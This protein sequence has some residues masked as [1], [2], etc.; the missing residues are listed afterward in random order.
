MNQKKAKSIANGVMLNAYPDSIGH[1]LSDTIQMLQKPEFKDVFA[2]F[3]V[4]PTFFNSDLD[5]GFS[6]LDYNLNKDLV[7]KED[8]IALEQLNIQLKFDIVLL[9]FV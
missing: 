1:K 2:L 3:Y 4:L 8:L 7:S 5:R 9:L 6:I